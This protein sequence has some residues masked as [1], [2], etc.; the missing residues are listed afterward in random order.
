MSDKEQ[1]KA[2]TIFRVEKRHNYTPIHR[3]SAEDK[4][5][6]WEAR[7]ILVFLLVKPDDW[8]VSLP[9]LINSGP[10]GRD[11]VRRILKELIEYNYIVKH[12]PRVESGQFGIPEYIVYELPYDGHFDSLK[13]N[14]KPET[15]NTASVNPQPDSPQTPN[16]PQLNIQTEPNKQLTNKTTTKADELIW[17]K[18]LSESHKE[19]LLSLVFG[20]E[21]EVI[22]LLLDELSGQIENIKNPVGYFRILVKNYLSGSFIP[23]KAIEVQAKREISHRNSLAVERSWQLAEEKVQNQI[24]NHSK[25]RK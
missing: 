15:K 1:G 8:Q 6:S 24:Q 5:L 11:K 9:H 7:G 4:R 10:A 25:G 13:P 23:A 3:Y 22:Q 16:H 20:L 2:T 12:Q 19:S 21:K 17:P 14:A 18:S